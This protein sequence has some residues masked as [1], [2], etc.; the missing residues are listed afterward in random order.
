MWRIF[1]PHR[2]RPIEKR[3]DGRRSGQAKSHPFEGEIGLCRYLRAG[4][5]GTMAGLE[6]QAFAACPKP[7]PRNPLHEGTRPR[8]VP[9]RRPDPSGRTAACPLGPARR[10]AASSRDAG[11][12][13]VAGAV[14]GNGAGGQAGS[15]LFRAEGGRKRHHVFLVEVNPLAV[16]RPARE[17]AHCA[18]V[19]RQAPASTR[20]SRP[21]PIIVDLAF[22]RIRGPR[23]AVAG[24]TMFLPARPALAA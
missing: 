16:A 13:R 8:T 9:T 20:C 3:H 5:P 4:C 14:R 12:G 10:Q 1:F 11:R 15:Y 18:W 6:R 17:I 21:T 23:V 24:T 22:E 7:L 19:D 2:S